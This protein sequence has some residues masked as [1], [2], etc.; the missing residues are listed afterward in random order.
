[1]NRIK[2]A[3]VP[4]LGPGPGFHLKMAGNLTGVIKPVSDQLQGSLPGSRDGSAGNQPGKIQRYE[5][6]GKLLTRIPPNGAENSPGRIQKILLRTFTLLLLLCASNSFSQEPG[7][8]KLGIFTDCQYCN[9]EANGNRQYRL[10]LAKLDS[11]IVVFNS[12]PLDAVFHLG[13]MIDHG[14]EN[15]DS[16]LPRFAKF[17]APLNL[18]L[19][20]HDYMIKTKYKAGLIDHV[21][22]PEDSRRMDAGWTQDGRR[23]EKGKTPGTYTL[24]ISNWR[25]IVLNGDDLSYFAPQ[26]QQQVNERNDMVG[27]QYMNLKSNGMP[28][29]GGIS[30][31]QMTW[32]DEQ[33]KA[34]STEGKNVIILCHFPLFGKE[35]HILF[36][37][38]EVYAL[39]SGYPCVKAWFNGHYHAGAYFFKDGIHLVNFKGMVDTK[40]NTF[41]VVRLTSDSILIKGY[42]RETDRKLKIRK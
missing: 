25:F 27:Q 23:V 11:C 17:K 1:M 29:N 26:D 8:V 37:S 32:L 42:G 28:W 31:K 41:A 22:L 40:Q 35:N 2:S 10:S 18:V 36:N 34:A 16:I 24:T 3:L 9:C 5:R 30:K 14:Y 38:K 13:D 12:L 39:I 4:G 21:G 33:L 7:P 6:Q 15:F 19:G 20:N